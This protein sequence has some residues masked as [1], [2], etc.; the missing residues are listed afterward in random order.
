MFLK[1]KGFIKFSKILLIAVIALIS[2]VLFTSTYAEITIT[3]TV[4][5]E[6]P[7]V[8]EI[9]ICETSCAYYKALNPATAF[10]IKVTAT[11]PNGAEDINWDATEIEIYKTADAND[12]ADADWDHL[13]LTVGNG[14]T[15]TASSNGCTASGDANCFD[16]G[17]GEWT[18]KFLNGGADVFVRVQDSNGTENLSEDTNEM[19]Y[20]ASDL[21]ILVGGT[22]G[23]T[24]DSTT[25]TF[26]GNQGTTNNAIVTSETNAYTISTHNGNQNLDVTVTATDLTYTTYTIGDDNISWYLTDDAGSSTPMTGGADAVISTWT[27]GTD[28]TSATQNVYYWVD[29]P[30]GQREGDYTGTFTYGSAAS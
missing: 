20:S 30:S 28:P 19:E 18:V 24:E 4:N 26:T 29:I 17:A 8:G 12:S 27:R 2:L 9:Q 5:N 14:L 23:I 1:N 25:G 16:V 15:Q 21:G 13:V 6:A 22:T 7:T 10:T 11:D 3:G